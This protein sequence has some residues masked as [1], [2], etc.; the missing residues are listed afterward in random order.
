MIGT[1]KLFITK[2]IKKNPTFQCRI[3][4]PVGRRF[5][6]A[7][8]YILY[9]TLSYKI[10]STSVICFNTQSQI[11]DMHTKS[12]IFYYLLFNLT[13]EYTYVYY[14]FASVERLRLKIMYELVDESCTHS[15][16][17]NYSLVLL[18][19]N[20]QYWYSRVVVLLTVFLFFSTD[21]C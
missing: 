2:Q 17:Y 21:R 15:Y 11:S 20:S 8:I 10:Y 18:L 13:Y 1:L 12:Y 14:Y 19:H 5:D 7:H 4:S 16:D 9:S 6:Y 3:S